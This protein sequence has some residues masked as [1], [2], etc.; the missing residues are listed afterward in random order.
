MSCRLG[1][2]FFTWNQSQPINCLPFNR[3]LVQS[4]FWVRIFDILKRVVA[5]GGDFFFTVLGGQALIG[6]G[7]A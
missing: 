5:S 6:V 1:V 2:E 3:R 7:V 4:L